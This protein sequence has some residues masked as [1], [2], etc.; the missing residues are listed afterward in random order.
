VWIDG[1]SLA[2]SPEVA[3]QLLSYVPDECPI[4]PFMTGK[5]L[6]QF[7]T[8]TKRAVVEEDLI[9]MIQDFNLGSQLDARFDAMS[10][11]TQKKVLLCAAVI[12]APRVVLMDEP[13][14]GLDRHARERLITLILSWR[15]RATILFATHDAEL[16]AATGA[17]SLEME[18]VLSPTSG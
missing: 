14:N 16:V 7:V 15:S 3:R 17:A 18:Q 1:Y 8:L 13:S 5:D 10:L 6:L 11:G 2:R 4:Y 9:Q 12:G